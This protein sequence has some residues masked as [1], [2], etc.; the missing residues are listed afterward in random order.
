MA[1]YPRA[2]IDALATTDATAASWCGASLMRA[3]RTATGSAA[4][5]PFAER[6]DDRD[7]SVSRCD[8]TERRT[9]DVA[10]GDIEWNV[11]TEG[12]TCGRSNV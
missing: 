9:G 12:S 10:T 2:T 1:S 5:K 7:S 11:S 4:S 3:A 8:G 6:A